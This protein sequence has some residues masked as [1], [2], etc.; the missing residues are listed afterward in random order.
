MVFV[1]EVLEVFEGD[2]AGEREEEEYEEVTVSS[3]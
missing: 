3:V 1:E 2:V